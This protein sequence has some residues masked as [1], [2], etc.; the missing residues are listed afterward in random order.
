MQA[1]VKRVLL[2]LEDRYHGKMW[3][4]TKTDL[5]PINATAAGRKEGSDSAKRFG[6]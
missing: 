2:R 5:R 3:L 4:E 6:P 1:L